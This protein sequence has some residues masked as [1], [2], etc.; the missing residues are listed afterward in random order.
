MIKKFNNGISLISDSK[1]PISTAWKLASKH[2]DLGNDANKL[3]EILENHENIF[4][5]YNPY[6]NQYHTAETIFSCA[7]LAKEEN[8]VDKYFETMIILLLGATFHDSEHPGR[9]NKFSFELE[10]KSTVF[11]K[12]WWHNNSLFV[13]NIIKMSPLYIE[14]AVV[15]LILFTDFTEGQKKVVY[16]YLN[17]KETTIVGLKLCKMKKILNEADF[18]LHCL[19]N[20]G[21]K[22]ISLILEESKISLNEEEK[23]NLYLD[24]LI[25]N[26][27]NLFSSD[28]AKELKIDLII[29][30]IINYLNLNKT[31]MSNSIKLQEEIEYKFKSI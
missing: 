15:E 1:K 7:F 19:P 5:N 9:T 24:F 12:N 13:E 10:E 20:Y 28:A 25:K 4:I 21:V 23:W 31:N 16:D 29:K 18:L 11:F 2:L 17:Q 22:K 26:G 14:Q 6:H 8:F 27:Q 3:I 30:K